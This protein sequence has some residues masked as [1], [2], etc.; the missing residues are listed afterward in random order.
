MTALLARIWRRLNAAQIAILSFALVILLGTIVLML[1]VSTEG[2]SM[3]FIDALF[4]STSAVC[5]TGL[6]VVDTGSRFSPAGQAVI[7]VLIQ[8]GGFGIMTFSTFIL[9]ML[10]RRADMRL[11]EAA[12]G[13]FLKLRR[14]DLGE[15]LRRALIFTLAVEG[16][17]AIILFSR[18]IQDFPSGRALW[19]SVFHAVSAFCN[20]GF[21]LFPD[22]LMGYGSDPGVNFTVMVL[23][24]AGG[25]GF[26]VLINI[27]DAIRGDPD[28]ARRRVSFHTRIVLTV[29]AAL[30]LGG[31]VLILS[32]EKNHSLAG[33]SW[34]QALMH[35]LFQS[36]TARTAGF[37]TLDI[38]QLSNASLFLL[39]IFMFVGGAP[40]S[41]AGGVKVTTL[42]V[43]VIVVISSLRGV[44]RPS[45]FGRAV[46]REDLERTVS[47]V[48]VAG[49]VI[50][51]FT[52][53]LLVTELGGSSH[54]ESRGLFMELLFEC[55]SA[56]GT[57][58]LSTGATP[59]LSPGGRVLITMVM[60]A[61]RLGPLTLAYAMQR[62]G[63]RAFF[64]YPEE[65][66]MIG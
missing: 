56:F 4:T 22:S 2:E 23:I 64:R 32:L 46:S 53:A 7:L 42:G 19:L 38:H 35:S 60:F 37:N 25:L 17:G 41:M 36:V 39:I 40:G 16:A 20:A 63:G 51:V 10:G 50:A 6:T 3:G 26:F 28:P 57:V 24:V 49:A 61:G 11:S 21:S 55:V 15:M 14:Y 47:L 9:F 33:M 27:W 52:M 5:V 66:I 30:I 44:S 18:F 48:L 43:I 59:S 45:L 65:R 8:V 31:T 58:G 62:R 12:A 1:P 29:S 13:S 54:E 34:G